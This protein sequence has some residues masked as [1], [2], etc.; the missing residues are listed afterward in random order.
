MVPRRACIQGV[1][2]VTVEVGGH[3]I[4]ALFCCHENRFFYHTNGSIATKL[5]HD[6]PRRACIKDV[7]KVK[8]ESKVT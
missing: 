7:L 5:T 6:L 2:K 3:V 4:R 1:L 8:V